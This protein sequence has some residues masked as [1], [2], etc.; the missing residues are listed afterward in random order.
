MPGQLRFPDELK[1]TA[2]MIHSSVIRGKAAGRCCN[3]SRRRL[4]CV[5][6]GASAMGVTSIFGF[7]STPSTS[8]RMISLTAPAVH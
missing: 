2:T 6:L 1:S 8:K 4:S 3:T 7:F 5:S